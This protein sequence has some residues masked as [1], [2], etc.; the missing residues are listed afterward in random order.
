M[1]KLATSWNGAISGDWRD[2]PLESVGG[3]CAL[4]GV[5]RDHAEQIVDDIATARMICSLQRMAVAGLTD[6]DIPFAHTK[7]SAGCA[8]RRDAQ[9]AGSHPRAYE[10]AKAALPPR[11]WRLE[12]ALRLAV[13]GAVNLQ[14]DGAS[15]NSHDGGGRTPSTVTTVPVRMTPPTWA[16]TSYANTSWP[17]GSSRRHTRKS[18]HPPQRDPARMFSPRTAAI[19]DLTN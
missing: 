9:A 7:S 5:P 2:W 15:V 12:R 11:Q 19:P 3:T 10:A 6:G 4:D 18:P 13:S 16:T 1:N 17:T 8:G 14:P